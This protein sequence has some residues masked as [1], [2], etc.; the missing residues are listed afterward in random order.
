MY[1]VQTFFIEGHIV[2]LNSTRHKGSTVGSEQLGVY[3]E[4]INKINKRDKHHGYRQHLLACFVFFL[5][6]KRFTVVLNG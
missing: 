1:A 2:F 5:G 3:C 6:R 4:I